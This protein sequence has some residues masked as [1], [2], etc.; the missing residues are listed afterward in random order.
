MQLKNNKLLVISVIFILIMQFNPISTSRISTSNN[1]NEC[2]GFIIPVTRNQS[3]N[4][5][6][7]ISKL[8]NELLRN[9]IEL[10]WI[11]N[12][13]YVFSK[14][15]DKNSS[16]DNNYFE[17]GSY[18]VP[19]SSNKLKNAIASSIVYKYN[20]DG[21]IKPYILMEPVNNIQVYKLVEP[22]I[23]V[24]NGPGVEVYSYVNCL[25]NSGFLNYDFLTWEEIPE[26]LNNDDY[27]VFV[28]GGGFDVPTDGVINLLGSGKLQKAFVSVNKFI[29][30][31]GGY[32]GS[33]G[34]CQMASSGPV[35]FPINLLQSFLPGN[36]I[37]PIGGVG[38][39]YIVTVLKTGYL[40]KFVK[41]GV[42]IHKLLDL[43]N[44][45]TYG[46]NEFVPIFYAH[47]PTIEWCGPNT[48]PLAVYHGIGNE[49]FNGTELP[50]FLKKIWLKAIIGKT[51]I[52]ESRIGDGKVVT[53]GSHPENDFYPQEFTDYP[54]TA[55]LV[56][57]S[58]YYVT[59]EGPIFINIEK[60]IN[61]S[62][63]RLEIEGPQCGDVSD[64]IE[65]HC[66]ITGGNPPYIYYWDFD[67]G[68]KSNI[69]APS[70]MYMEP[71][72]FSVILTVIDQNEKINV[73]FFEINISGE[74]IVNNSPPETPV[75]FYG[76][77]FKRPGE[78]VFFRTNTKDPDGDL[79][80]YRLQEKH[81]DIWEDIWDDFENESSY[82]FES[83]ENCEF[84]LIWIEEKNHYI[85]FKAIDVH[86]AES[87]WSEPIEI[88]ITKHPF[89][90]R[91]FN[92]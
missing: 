30:N 17:N 25:R 91:I 43:D 14:T 59:S 45:V 48:K 28:W 3:N 29:K 51:G 47:G 16:V 23:A 37:P 42:V 34:G 54:S 87:K 52:V 7:E 81:D 72:N 90:S 15:F 22:K 64:I 68:T 61:F 80:W 2:Y 41:G 65:F 27:N 89:I 5:Q 84:P 57:N 24:H 8:V 11:T 50:D 55:R 13:T 69:S 86:G 83:G 21:C 70:H 53:F 71:G 4:I 6:M 73:T 38:C 77:R 46:I 26:K 74:P 1:S 62:D 35:F 88:I 19:F 67:D 31:G 85:R 44:P 82:L 78:K 79:F 92:R 39:D 32:I 20:I 9:D 33:C 12:Q 60:D 76:K 75:E 10:Y 63:L 49:F 40:G 18:I 66:N 58:L 56:Y 36:I